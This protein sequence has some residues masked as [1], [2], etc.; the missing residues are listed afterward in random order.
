M[1]RRLFSSLPAAVIGMIPPTAPP[2]SVAVEIAVQGASDVD[3]QYLI[4]KI[5]QFIVHHALRVS[6][7]TIDHTETKSYDN[8][9]G[10]I[11]PSHTYHYSYTGEYR[12]GD[13]STPYQP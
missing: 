9:T 3:A 1:T 11:S 7:N 4:A 6:V 5:A 10:L 13:P 8:V 2:A 12:K